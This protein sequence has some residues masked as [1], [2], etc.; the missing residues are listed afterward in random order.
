VVDEMMPAWLWFAFASVL[1]SL[2]LFL[3]PGT[4]TANRFGLAG[5]TKRVSSPTTAAETAA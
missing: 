2:W 5:N 3:M 4:T 1:V